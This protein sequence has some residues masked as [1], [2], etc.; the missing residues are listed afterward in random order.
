MH[1][2]L[3]RVAR[4]IE[5]LH[6]RDGLHRLVVLERP[7][8]FFVR[9]QGGKIM[10]FII[11]MEEDTSYDS[12]NYLW[13]KDRLYEFCYI[14][15]VVIDEKVR[16][17]GWATK[18]YDLV[19]DYAGKDLVAEVSVL[20]KANKESIRFHEK[21]GFKDMGQFRP[22]K[23]KRKVTTMYRLDDNEKR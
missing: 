2:A 17:K 10:G 21:Y 3:E 22:Y 6:I 12:L 15:R 20:P 5:N 13:F 4:H 1:L 18:L 11:A 8:H 23:G 9:E 14:D 7:D 19:Y 16:R